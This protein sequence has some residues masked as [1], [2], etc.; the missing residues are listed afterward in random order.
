VYPYYP[1]FLNFY[2]D[3]EWDS[4]GIGSKDL[5]ETGEGTTNTYRA[6][7]QMLTRHHD[8]PV[9]IAE[10]G[11][12]SSHGL[13]QPDINMG[14]DQ[15]HLSEQQQG[16]ALIS[17]YR[18]IMDAGCVGSLLA[19]W[20]D[21]WYKSSF[22]SS[23]TADMTRTPYWLNWGDPEQFMGLLAME[24]GSDG[25]CCILDGNI[26]D[27]REK[28]IVACGKD[29]STLYAKYDEGY[30]YLCIKGSGL[31]VEDD[32]YY[33]PMDITPKSGS[34]YCENHDVKFDREADFL[35]VIDGRDG[36]RL[37]VQE[38][39]EVLRALY[40]QEAYGFNTYGDDHVPAKNS[41]EFR[42]IRTLA[43]HRLRVDEEEPELFESGL[44]IYGSTD[45]ENP[46]FHSLAGFYA[47]NDVIELRIPWYLLNFY[48]PS[49][50]RVHDDYYEV[51]GVAHTSVERIYLGLGDGTETSRIALAPLR[52]SAWVNNVSYH[53]RLKQSYYMMQSV[54]KE[55]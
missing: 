30:L 49:L 46:D 44:L 22:C 11:V 31:S 45:P 53:E 20:H 13:A 10:F 38:R 28:D 9:V 41:P 16:E 55:D 32:V 50:M 24:P 39:Y 21:E 23:K 8:M 51:Y 47:D 7:L 43:Q 48:D 29:G 34:N 14:R 27:W 25:L 17:C 42:R 15:G 6:Y 18:D 37:L 5:Y 3:H 36:T 4:L 54:W 52:M 35:L 26:S 12:P 1:D 2:E 19:A 40:A 33:V